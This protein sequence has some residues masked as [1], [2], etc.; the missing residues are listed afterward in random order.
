MGLEGTVTVPR[1]R[2]QH[3]CAPAGCAKS[4]TAAESLV[5]R[6]LDRLELADYAEES[7]AL[8]AASAASAFASAFN[9]RFSTT[10]ASPIDSS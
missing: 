5:N 10:L 8:R 6:Q 1:L 9:R 7:F 4:D 2:L 3:A